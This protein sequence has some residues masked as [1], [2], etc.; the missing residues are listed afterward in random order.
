MFGKTPKQKGCEKNTGHVFQK[1]LKDPNI[2]F[3][4]LPCLAQ[5]PKTR[6]IIKTNFLKIKMWIFGLITQKHE[7]HYMN[8]ETKLKIKTKSHQTKGKKKRTC[9]NIAK[10]HIE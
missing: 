3:F 9:K 7:K 1:H 10:R 2:Y 5:I 8:L 6:P 4:R